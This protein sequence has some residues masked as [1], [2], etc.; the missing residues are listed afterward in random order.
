MVQEQ[1]AAAAPA[2]SR[3]RLPLALGLI[4]LALIL[5][6]VAM[7]AF[8]PFHYQALHGAV[9]TANHHLYL[10]NESN[11]VWKDVRL[12]LDTDFKLNTPSLAPNATFDA[13]LTQ[14]KKDDGTTFNAN[15]SL[16]D[17][18]VT[19][20]TPDKHT[21]SNIYQFNKAK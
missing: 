6:W 16:T 13:D 21:I 5:G 17:L 4:G 14:F 10:T 20:V 18:Y 3:S 9:R 15:Y 8:Y 12:L 1:T 2:Q 7:V 19:A 11:Y